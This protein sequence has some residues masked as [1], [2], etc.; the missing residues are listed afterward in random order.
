M[1]RF[2]DALMLLFGIG[3]VT[4]LVAHKETATIVDAGSKGI[5]TDLHTAMTA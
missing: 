3:L 1:D 2:F 4:T 5:A